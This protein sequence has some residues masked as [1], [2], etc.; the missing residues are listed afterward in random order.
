MRWAEVA[1]SPLGIVPLVIYVSFRD[2]REIA[3]SSK[4]A[5]NVNSQN[6]RLN[7]R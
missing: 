1:L 6:S 3:E 2:F 4:T 7:C 5:V